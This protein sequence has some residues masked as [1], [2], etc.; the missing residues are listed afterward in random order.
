MIR[1]ACITDVSRLAEILVFAKRSAYRNIFQNDKVSFGEMQV[2][3]LALEFMNK[4]ALLENIIVF[5]DEFV[6]GMAK[7]VK[8]KNNDNLKIVEIEEIYVD[9][10]FQCL[11]IGGKLL[12]E[13][14]SFSKQNGYHNINLWVLEKNKDARQFYEKHQ[15]TPTGEKKIEQGTS[16]YLI[17]YSIQI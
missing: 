5:D 12:L 14:Q 4:P 6:K 11:G 9:P 3:P 15:F 7:V 8:Y 13:I 10:F 2:L 17:Q 1:K 16:E